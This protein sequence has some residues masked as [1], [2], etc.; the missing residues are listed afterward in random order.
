MNAYGV[1]I[2]YQEIENLLSTQFP[3]LVSKP[4][5]EFYNIFWEKVTITKLLKEK[6]Q[7]FSYYVLIVSNQ[8]RF[9]D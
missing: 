2:C 3:Q 6:C 9:L 5:G 4:L 8:Q 7:L 1:E